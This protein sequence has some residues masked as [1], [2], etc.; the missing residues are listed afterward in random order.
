MSVKLIAITRNNYIFS[1]AIIGRTNTTQGPNHDF[2][3]SESVQGSMMGDP[4]SLLGLSL[5]TNRCKPNQ[6]YV[7]CLPF[8]YNQEKHPF[9]CKIFS[10]IL[11]NI[12]FNVL[13]LAGDPSVYVDCRGI[14]FR[15]N[16]LCCD[17]E[18][19]HLASQ[20]SQSVSSHEKH[21]TLPVASRSR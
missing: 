4:V 6:S 3:E 11:R 12:L 8:D 2:I 20:V 16:S 17:R 14:S 15:M 21:R 18:V 13:L 1:S 19:S 5:E 9:T 10:H 7:W